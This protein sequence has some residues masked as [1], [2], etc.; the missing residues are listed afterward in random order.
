MAT[1]SFTVTRGTSS[2]QLVCKAKTAP[3]IAAESCVLVA[4]TRLNSVAGSELAIWIQAG[5]SKG[6]NQD[7]DWAAQLGH[8]AQKLLSGPE[9]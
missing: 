8:R 7:L 1:V 4:A 9:S 6:L 2:Q 3:G 5:M